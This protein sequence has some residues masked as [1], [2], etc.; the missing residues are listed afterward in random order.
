MMFVDTIIQAA[1]DHARQE[2]PREACGFVVSGEYLPRNNTAENPEVDFRVSPQAWVAAEA[3]GEIEAVIHSHPNGPAHPSRADMESQIRTGLAWGIVPMVKGAAQVPFF[4]GGDTPVQPLIGRRFRS[5]VADCYALARDWYRLEQ[6]VVLPDF[7]REPG[8][9]AEEDLFMDN[10]RG[11]GFEPVDDEPR[12]GD[13]ILMQVCSRRVSH[14]AVYVG[15]G[16]MLH[17]LTRR[18][19]C[20]EPMGRWRKLIRFVVRRVAS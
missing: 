17:H 1:M 14:C 5:G 4:W 16:L 2:Y 9:E 3:V 6:G 12:I 8:W 10:F 20:T 11:A 19:S 15:N 13:G 18:Q 7:P